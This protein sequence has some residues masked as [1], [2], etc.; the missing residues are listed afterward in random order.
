MEIYDRFRRRIVDEDELI[1]HRMAW[2]TLAQTGLFAAFGFA[3]IDLDRVDRLRFII[4]IAI[5]LVGMAIAILTWLSISAAQSEIKRTVEVYDALKTRDYAGK[6]PI[7]GS[8]RNHARG[9]WLPKALPPLLCV[10][11]LFVAVLVTM[12]FFEIIRL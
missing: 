11:W 4:A 2:G 9:H 8:S 5:A 6:L 7:T 3:S 12:R 1:N 10:L